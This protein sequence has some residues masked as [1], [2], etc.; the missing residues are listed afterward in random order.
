[1]TMS[2]TPAPAVPMPR[3][4]LR[5]RQGSVASIALWA[6]RVLLAVQFVGSGVLKLT[7]DP[8]MV[9]MFADIGSGQ[10]LRLLVGVCE[11]A[12]ALGLLVPRLARAAAAGLVLLM[13]GAAVTDAAVLQTSPA[14]PVVFAA[15]A[16]GVLVALTALSANRT[17]KED[18]R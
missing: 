4:T 13:I 8:S 6:V 17:P 9:A 16:A 14:I 11:V 1:M 15:L 3:R 5:P 10:E 12:G 18:A 7:A 2:T